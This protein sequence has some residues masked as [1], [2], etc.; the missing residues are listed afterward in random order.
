MHSD[1]LN[2]VVLAVVGLIA[3]AFGVA[4]LLV[5]FDVLPTRRRDEAVIA[6]RVGRYVGVH[7]DWLWPAIAAGG[8]LVGVL[9]LLWLRRL[10]RGSDRVAEL[11]VVSAVPQQDRPAGTTRLTSAALTSAVCGQLGAYREVTACRARVLGTSTRAVLVVD[12]TTTADVDIAQLLRR[13]DADVLADA[14]SAVGDPTLPIDLNVT[15]ADTKV[16]RVG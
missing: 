8:V 6:N 3:L 2:R 4:T 9:A 7:G 10:L 15:V 13:V 1:R 14:R 12:L 5:G 16:A 11:T